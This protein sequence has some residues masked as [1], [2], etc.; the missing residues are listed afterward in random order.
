MYIFKISK[1]RYERTIIW[2]FILFFLAQQQKRAP[3]SVFA[4]LKKKNYFCNLRSLY[5]K[6]GWQSNIYN[7]L[8]QCFKHE[9]SGFQTSWVKLACSVSWAILVQ[10]WNKRTCLLAQVSD[11]ATLQ[12]WW[13]QTRDDST[14]QFYTSSHQYLKLHR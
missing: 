8:L 3:S 14:F 13:N 12:C 1:S 4:K 2:G 11:W 7:T 9:Q 5:L 6:T 10:C